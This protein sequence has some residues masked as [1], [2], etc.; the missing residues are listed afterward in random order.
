MKKLCLTLLCA[1]ALA[2]SANIAQAKYDETMP[3]PPPSHMQQT[4]QDMHNHH[5]K[6]HNK[7]AEEL[8]LTDKQKAKAK[9]MRQASRK[10]IKPL[11]KEMKNLREKIDKIRKEN[12][13]EFEK[14]LTPEQRE[15]FER[16]K[17]ERK[18]KHEEMFK[19]H[20]HHA[21]PPMPME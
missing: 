8:K 13:K 7:L 4:Q 20:H 2:Y 16:I 10:K 11:M 3:P 12:M 18:A 14:L 9:E 21:M 5:E 15:T 1:T 17:A 19:K 6:M